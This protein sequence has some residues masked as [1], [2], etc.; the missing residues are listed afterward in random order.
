[1]FGKGE[2]RKK[3]IIDGFRNGKYLFG[4]FGKEE[5]IKERK[6]I[7]KDENIS[8]IHKFLS[9]QCLKEK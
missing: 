9:F 8:G 2:K 1:M 6:K 4:L 3:K 5:K 7:K